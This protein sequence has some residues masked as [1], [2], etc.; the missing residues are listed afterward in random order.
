VVVVREPGGN[1]CIKSELAAIAG[2]RPT[3]QCASAGPAGSREALVVVTD[4]IPNCGSTPNCSDTTLK[5]NA[6]SAANTAA[7]DNMDVYT[8]YYG[9]STSDAAWLATLIRGNGIALKT[10]TAAQLST[11]MQ[12]VCSQMPH[13]LVW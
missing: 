1:I 4:G 5:N 13:R 6:V 10:P 2:M 3:Q 8:I 12:Q 11:L 9:T 7:A